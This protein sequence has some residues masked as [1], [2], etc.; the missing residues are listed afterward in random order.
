[1]SAVYK[2]CLLFH[3]DEDALWMMNRCHHD[4]SSPPPRDPLYYHLDR[5]RARTNR[6]KQYEQLLLFPSL[7]YL[8]RMWRSSTWKHRSDLL[9]WHYLT[10]SRVPVQVHRGEI[11]ITSEHLNDK[12]PTVCENCRL[13]QHDDVLW[14]KRCLRPDPT[15]GFRPRWAPSI[16]T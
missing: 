2:A 4:I 3:H 13:L 12:L 10:I 14:M 11:D 16:K 15:I 1:M 7:K 6:N 5:P 9:K 8:H